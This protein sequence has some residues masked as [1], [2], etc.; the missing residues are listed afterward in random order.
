MGHVLFSMQIEVIGQIT[1]DVQQQ[2][3]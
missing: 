1:I 3:R 2:A